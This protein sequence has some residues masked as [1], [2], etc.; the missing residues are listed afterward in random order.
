[1]DVYDQNQFNNSSLEG[2]T[3]AANIEI[4]SQFS[5]PSGHIAKP[6][7]SNSSIVKIS[8]A[9]RISQLEAKNPTNLYL[10]NFL[11]SSHLFPSSCRPEDSC[12]PGRGTNSPSF[13]TCPQG[14]LKSGEEQPATQLR[15]DK[16]ARRKKHT[17][18]CIS[19]FAFCTAIPMK[20]AM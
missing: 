5:K 11:K 19:S 13:V 12:A 1:M 9:N 10:Q 18:F 4:P 15:N 14:Y 3:S 16:I 7:K 20:I 17:W 6:P 2:T 8:T